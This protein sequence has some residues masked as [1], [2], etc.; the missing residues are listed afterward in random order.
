MST[1]VVKL[2]DWIFDVDIDLT[3]ERSA[4][5]AQEHC[6]CSYCRNFYRSL[7]ASNP[8]MRPFLAVFGIDPMGPDELCPFEPTIYEV[9]YIVNGTILQ[10]GTPFRIGDIPVKVLS[11]TDADMD[12]ERSEP[13]FVLIIGLLELPWALDEDPREVISP[14]NEDSFLNRMKAKLLARITDDSPLS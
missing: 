1:I 9:S 11:S 12:T 3:M 7:D 8:D 14:A 5:Q 10:T 13:Y 2:N 4:Y 6:D